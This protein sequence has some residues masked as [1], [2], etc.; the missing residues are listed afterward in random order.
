MTAPH[1]NGQ[2]QATTTKLLQRIPRGYSSMRGRNLHTENAKSSD[3][4]QRRYP[5]FRAPHQ[6]GNETE[7]AGVMHMISLL[8]RSGDIQSG[9]VFGTSGALCL[10]CGRQLFAI[11]GLYFTAIRTIKCHSFQPHLVRKVRYSCPH[12]TRNSSTHHHGYRCI[13]EFRVQRLALLC[14]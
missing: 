14:Q 12:E 4:R 10:A 5:G 1:N 2:R 13:C 3:A 11:L 7:V 6:L 8:G 9:T